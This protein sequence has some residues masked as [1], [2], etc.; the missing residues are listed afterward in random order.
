MNQRHTIR[1]AFLCQALA[2]GSMFTRIPDLQAGLGVDEGVLGLCLLGQP[3]GAI[4]TFLVS[5]RLVEALGTRVV[6]LWGIPVAALLVGLMP[7]APTPLLLFL[8]FALY[9]ITF[10]LTNVAMNVEADRVEAASGKRLMNSCHG[11][12]SIGQ[13][14][15]VTVGALAR[16]FGVPAT[17]H[18]GAIVPLI[19][20]AALVILWPM[21]GAPARAHTRA[22]PQKGLSLP[23]IATVL[24]VGYAIGGAILEAAVRNWS[25][26]FMRD[27][28]TAPAWVDTLTLPAFIGATVIGRL[29]ADQFITRYGP[30][31]FA[32]ILGLISLVGLALVVMSP[33][34]M[35]ALVGFAFVGL[36]VCVSFPLSTSAAARLGDRPA[37][38]NVAALTMTT[39][40]TL[41][42][43]P[44]LLGW[45]AASFG[46]RSTFVVVV[47]VVVLAIFLAKYLAPKVVVQ[48]T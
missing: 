48:T 47:P 22:G 28:F 24:L 38:E 21:Q 12:W 20:V 16:G 25:V 37:S 43:T 3:V 2:T 13:L 35:V 34:L 42:G 6:L 11:I 19:L 29:L 23:T 10:A 7:Q 32:R 9:G 27:S 40:I 31:R 5:S 30:V 1:L 15:T 36:G 41:L 44:A 18:L 17:V 26:I 39:Q 4:L 45:I 33:N 8:V 14:V 46:I